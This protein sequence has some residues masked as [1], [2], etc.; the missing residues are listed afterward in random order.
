M[1]DGVKL[2]VVLSGITAILLLIRFI[3]FG[4]SS[5]DIQFGFTWLVITFD[6]VVNLWLLS[7]AFFLGGTIGS[8]FRMY[9]SIPV[10]VLLVVSVKYLFF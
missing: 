6:W 4:N 7:F 3:A 10:I 1:Q 8:R 5:L 9:F 2:G